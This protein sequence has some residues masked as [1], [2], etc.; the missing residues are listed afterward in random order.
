MAVR[1]DAWTCLLCAHPRVLE[2][3]VSVVMSHARQRL[4]KLAWLTTCSLDGTRTVHLFS[5]LM[6]C[7]CLTGAFVR[8]SHVHF[9]NVLTSSSKTNKHCICIV[10]QS[11][12][13]TIE[14]AVLS[15]H[16]EEA[17]RPECLNRIILS[18]EIQ[19]VLERRRRRS[20]GNMRGRLSGI[21]NGACGARVAD[22]WRQC[23]PQCWYAGIIVVLSCPRIPK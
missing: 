12:F 19:T 4:P 9:V 17:H 11:L 6:S 16:M 5:C 13:G 1:R 8:Y 20:S 15:K 18:A 10:T 14:S 7:I 2:T 21:C 22:Q 23:K 3:H